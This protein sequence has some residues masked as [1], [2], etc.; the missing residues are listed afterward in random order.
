MASFESCLPLGVL[1]ASWIC[2]IRNSSWRSMSIPIY[3]PPYR[4]CC[5]PRA[6]LPILPQM[7]VIGVTNPQPDSRLLRCCFC[8]TA[9]G[10]YL[11]FR[12]PCTVQAPIRSVRCFKR[13][14]LGRP[15]L[16]SSAGHIVP[17]SLSGNPILFAFIA[18]RSCVT[19]PLLPGAAAR[20]TDRY[21]DV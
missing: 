10:R 3:L 18:F 9:L 7:P 16:L 5:S 8:L 2:S 11:R 4:R 21:K 19:A 1:V 15:G 20:E 13:V 6:T 14:H 17:A 12:N